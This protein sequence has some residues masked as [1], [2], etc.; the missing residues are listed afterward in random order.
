M[1]RFMAPS[2]ANRKWQAKFRHTNHRHKQLAPSHCLCFHPQT[3]QMNNKKEFGGSH[4]TFTSGHIAYLWVLQKCGQD[5]VV[6]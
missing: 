6:R 3:Q 5:A 1:I 4:F 2:L